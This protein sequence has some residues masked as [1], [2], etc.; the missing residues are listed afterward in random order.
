MR[1]ALACLFTLPLVWACG[2]KSE[3]SAPA[4]GQDASSTAVKPPAAT[5][6]EPNPAPAAPEPPSP[7][8]VPTPAPAAPSCAFSGLVMGGS[9]GRQVAQEAS[10]RDLATAVGKEVGTDEDTLAALCR[11]QSPT[12]CN[13]DMVIY[14][15]RQD[16][17]R[18]GSALSVFVRSGKAG[19]G[20]WVGFERLIPSD[21]NDESEVVRPPVVFDD[22]RLV[23]IV[24]ARTEQV[25]GSQCDPEGG[26]ELDSETFGATAVDIVIDRERK[27]HVFTSFASAWG[28]V[29]CDDHVAPSLVDGAFVRTDCSGKAEPFTTDELA[30]CTRRNHE[31]WAATQAERFQAEKTRAEGVLR[32]RA[33]GA[34]EAAEPKPDKMTAADHLAEG[35]R[36]T[37]EKKYGEAIA[38]FTAASDA[39][40][41]LLEALSGRCYAKVLRAQGDDL[42]GAIDDCDS[43]RTDIQGSRYDGNKRFT[44][45]VSFNIGLAYEKLGQTAEALDAFEHANTVSP[46]EA[47]AK[48]ITALKGQ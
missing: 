10:L 23:A 8:A 15:T 36:L 24:V 2:S 46:S 34:A 11:G 48:K 32:G 35:R 20:P 22:G 6:G 4:A 9:E 47:A 25:F 41:E 14:T 3:V 16:D 30:A 39:D 5:P 29:R 43:V 13:A 27:R 45:A 17:G 1:L 40:P 33:G 42:K 12:T 38:A 28:D 18:N 19:D 37:R 44:S 26:C 31:T 7:A 21:A